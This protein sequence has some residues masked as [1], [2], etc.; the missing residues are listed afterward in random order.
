MKAIEVLRRMTRIR[1][2]TLQG[3]ENYRRLA[4]K[5]RGFREL[6]HSSSACRAFLSARNQARSSLGTTTMEAGRAR[7]VRMSFSP[8]QTS[9]VEEVRGTA[10]TGVATSI[11][12]GAQVQ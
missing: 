3:K 8:S 7:S 12:Q 2:S 1:V 9:L 11:D 10:F 6:V 4:A 5:R